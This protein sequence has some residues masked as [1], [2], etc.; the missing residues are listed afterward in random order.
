MYISSKYLN[1]SFSDRP[2]GL[3]LGII[4]NNLSSYF[5]IEHEQP[6]LLLLLFPSVIIVASTTGRLNAGQIV[7]SSAAVKII[8]FWATKNSIFIFF[9]FF[10]DSFGPLN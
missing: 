5:A 7:C 4:D 2:D 9:N 10:P 6:L 8:K 3:S 1:F